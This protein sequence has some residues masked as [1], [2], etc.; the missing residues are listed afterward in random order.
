MAATKYLS[1]KLSGHNAR[2]VYYEAFKHGSG[3]VVQEEFDQINSGRFIGELH[4][5]AC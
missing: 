2:S 5:Y 3:S 1:I 4:K